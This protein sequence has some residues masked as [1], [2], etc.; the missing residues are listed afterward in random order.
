VNN[1]KFPTRL[2]CLTNERMFDFFVSL[3]PSSQYSGG[4]FEARG[5]TQVTSYPPPPI[6]SAYG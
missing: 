3:A 6:T 1:P 5:V 2:P 4:A